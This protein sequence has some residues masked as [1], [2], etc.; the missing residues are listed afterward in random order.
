MSAPL[1]FK[2]LRQEQEWDAKPCRL[3]P[4]LVAIVLAAAVYAFSTYGW[5]FRLT[6]LFRTPE[7]DRALG[8]TGVHCVGRAAD[9]RTIGVRASWV[10]DVTNWINARWIYDLDRPDLPVAYSKP[11]GD[12]PHLHIQVH[13]GTTRRT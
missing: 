10:E 11:H 7:E 13:P 12:A 4:R 1:T 9:I 3:H 5:M 2:T 6:C 8:G